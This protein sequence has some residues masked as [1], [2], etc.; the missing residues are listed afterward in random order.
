MGKPRESVAPDLVHSDSKRITLTSRAPFS[1]NRWSEES[2]QVR[3]AH[4]KLDAK[5]DAERS[6]RSRRA[7]VHKCSLIYLG[8][9]LLI[10]QVFAP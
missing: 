10:E 9:I 7:A 8:V 4:S 6:A 1:S 2:G 5:P 3:V